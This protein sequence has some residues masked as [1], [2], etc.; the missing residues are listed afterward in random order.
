MH[1]DFTETA[2]NIVCSMS[3]KANY[4]DNARIERFFTSL[5]REWPGDR[6]YNNHY[7]ARI[8]HANNN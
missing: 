2:W 5:T 1:P 3:H 4:G 8:L 6:L 7:V